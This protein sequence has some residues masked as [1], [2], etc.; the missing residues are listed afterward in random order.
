MYPDFF[1]TTTVGATSLE[2]HSAM[3]IDD[4]DAAADLFSGGAHG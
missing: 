2:L 3:A 1:P 4:A